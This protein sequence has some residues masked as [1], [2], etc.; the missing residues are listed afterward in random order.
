VTR[1]NYIAAC[2]DIAAEL[3]RTDATILDAADRAHSA[4]FFAAQDD[5]C[6][7]DAATAFVAAIF[8]ASCG[9][10]I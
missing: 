10:P 4:A 1:S 8:L 7:R 5:A 3:A 2:A 9:W 6:F